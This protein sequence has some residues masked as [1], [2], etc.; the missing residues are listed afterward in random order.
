MADD[1]PE[2]HEITQEHGKIRR[3]AYRFEPGAKAGASAIMWLP[4]FQSRMLG[5]KADAVAVFARQR[6]AA[7]MRFDY[8]GHGESPGTPEDGVV[9]DWIAESEAIFHRM[10]GRRTILVGSSMGAWIALLLA[11]RLAGVEALVLIA[12]AW[13]M[14]EDLMWAQ[15]TPQVRDIIMNEGCYRLPSSYEAGG[16]Q[17]SHRLIEDGRKHSIG[18]GPFGVRCPVRIIHGL[19]DADVPYQR[20]VELMSLLA[21][22]DV[23]LICVKDAEH[24]LARPQDLALLLQV[25]GEFI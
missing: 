8:S 6:G 20:S 7:L 22:D 23:R 12:P 14:T 21:N 13:N 3:I 18:P 25:L 4:G 24:R 16:Y 19:R 5:E 11:Q 1:Q 9:S 2:Y 15:F 10:E 17:I